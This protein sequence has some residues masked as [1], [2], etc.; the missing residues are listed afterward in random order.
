M[1]TIYLFEAQYGYADRRRFLVQSTSRFAAEIL[2][3][4][5]HPIV[6]DIEFIEAFD[7]LITNGMEEVAGLKDFKADF[8]FSEP[9]RTKTEC[10]N[11][12][13]H[14]RKLHRAAINCDRLTNITPCWRTRILYDRQI[15]KGEP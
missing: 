3:E 11:P 12:E 9:I 4:K 14:D 6:R 10:S 5:E 13:F 1:K 8:G 2:L 15:E 7:N